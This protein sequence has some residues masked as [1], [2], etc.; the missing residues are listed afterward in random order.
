M[1]LLTNAF[2]V[3]AFSRFRIYPFLLTGAGGDSTLATRRLGRMLYGCTGRSWTIS[4]SPGF[5]LIY[6]VQ[7][8]T[9]TFPPAWGCPG[10]GGS[11]RRCAGIVV[12]V[13]SRR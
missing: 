11:D 4:S 6:E 12:V 9:T 7:V 5:N 3:A 1:V 8:G 10:R 13:E 2:A